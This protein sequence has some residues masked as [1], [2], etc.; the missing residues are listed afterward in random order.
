[1]I[2]KLFIIFNGSSVSNEGF[3]SFRV[4]CFSST[5]YLHHYSVKDLI[6]TKVRDLVKLISARIF[7]VPQWITFL[8]NFRPILKVTRF[9][10]QTNEKSHLFRFSSSAYA[11]SL[12]LKGL[13][14]MVWIFQPFTTKPLHKQHTKGQASSF[15]EKAS[16]KF[17]FVHY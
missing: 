5:S 17:H 16:L 7:F 10:H 11:I 8:L 12:L 15:S 6:K 2:K 14:N 1:M 13:R 4:S 9:Y 3:L